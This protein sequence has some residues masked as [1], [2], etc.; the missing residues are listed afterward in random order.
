VVNIF[1]KESYIAARNMKRFS[2][3]TDGQF[4]S[5]EAKENKKILEAQQ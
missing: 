2:R 5:E 1:G 4:D 3:G